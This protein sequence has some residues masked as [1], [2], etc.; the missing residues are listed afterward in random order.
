MQSLSADRQPSKDTLNKKMNTTW[1]L[2][3]GAS[4]H[5]ANNREYF[6]HYVL[7]EPHDIQMGDNLPIQAVGIGT[8]YTV[9]PSNGS[10]AKMELRNVLHILRHA[11]LESVMLQSDDDQVYRKIP[12]N[13]NSVCGWNLAQ[14]S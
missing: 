11:M 8:I 10:F 6:V 1:Y 2:D 12:Q 3:S 13:S 14:T 7:M 9:I 4:D 5:M